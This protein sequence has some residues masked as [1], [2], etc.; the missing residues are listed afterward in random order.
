MRYCPWFS[1]FGNQRLK[2]H[3]KL[4]FIHMHTSNEVFVFLPLLGPDPQR[5]SGVDQ[6]RRGSGPGSVP[7][8]PVSRGLVCIK[9]Y[10][11][12]RIGLYQKDG[13]EMKPYLA[14][15]IPFY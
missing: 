6:H 3:V 9:S 1:L 8:V 14:V 7:R 15:H 2:L 12:G 4:Y 5:E 11:A 10:E 13:Y